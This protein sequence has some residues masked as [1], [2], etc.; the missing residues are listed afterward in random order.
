MNDITTISGFIDYVYGMYKSMKSNRINLAYEGEINH[1]IMKAFTSL[2]ES[3]M[4]KIEENSSV[5]R[6][7]FHVMVECLQN[8]GKY[9][10][11]KEHEKDEYG[12]GIFMVQ[13]GEDSY[14]VI[15]GNLIAK[16]NVNDLRNKLTEI[17]ELDKDG[18]KKLKKQTL[19]TGKLSEK[20]GAGLGLI[21]IAKKT[22]EK[23]DFHFLPINEITFFYILKISIKR[24]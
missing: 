18:L 4:E 5:Q 8:I 10:F 12:R 11:V 24:T 14:N 6:K 17:N 1:Q 7:V 9:G 20:G 16:D 13:R 22:G 2:A 19:K 15:T 3:D 21:D 23:L